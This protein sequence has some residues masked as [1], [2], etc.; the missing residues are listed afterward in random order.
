[1]RSLVLACLGVFL[2]GCETTKPEPIE[3]PQIFTHFK[4]S[5]SAPSELKTPQSTKTNLHIT[6]PKNTKNKI[7]KPPAKTTDLWQYIANNLHFPIE[8]KSAKKSVLTG[9]CSNPITC[10]L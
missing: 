6:P 8:Q 5:Y 10:K 2:F 4:P 7:I 3:A 9:I 1:M